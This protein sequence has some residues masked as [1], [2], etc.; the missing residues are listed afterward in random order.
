MHFENCASVYLH[1]ERLEGERE[2]ILF[3]RF[4]SLR[5]RETIVMEIG[6]VP[7]FSISLK[8]HL[9]DGVEMGRRYFFGSKTVPRE[10]EP[11][12]ISL[13]CG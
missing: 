10:I 9:A 4:F 11:F 7:F 2:K 5:A 8:G 6:P 3:S 12:I 13:S 1:F